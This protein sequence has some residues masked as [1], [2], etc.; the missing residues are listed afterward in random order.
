M[1]RSCRSGATRASF[2]AGDLD[3]SI[4]HPPFIGVDGEAR[5]VEVRGSKRLESAV[6]RCVANTLHRVLHFASP[7]EG[8]LEVTL[9]YRFEPREGAL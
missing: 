9:P 6:G 2:G 5:H 4:T 1:G 3:S 7:A 8:P